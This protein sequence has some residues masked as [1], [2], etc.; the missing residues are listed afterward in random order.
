MPRCLIELRA[1]GESIGSLV[2]T[3]MAYVVWAAPK[4]VGQPFDQAA[5]RRF[6]P[7]DLAGR[8]RS[9]FIWDGPLA[10]GS[11]A[12]NARRP[13][14]A[15]E[16]SPGLASMNFQNMARDAAWF[17][18]NPLP[19][20]CGGGGIVTPPQPWSPCPDPTSVFDNNN[21]DAVFNAPAQPT[22]FR[23]DR[24]TIM[25]E[26]LTYHWNDGSGTPRPGTVSLR[27][28]SGTVYGP[29]TMVGRPGSGGAPN[30]YWVATPNAIVPAGAYTVE[31]SDPGTWARNR[32]SGEAGMTQIKGCPAGR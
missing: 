28:A 10:G 15:T 5:W 13:E 14:G 9:T 7:W 11:M 23:L 27:D 32:Q 16:I 30:A 4:V 25:T 24:P 22:T 2:K 21:I 31:D 29:W 1:G 8:Q 3:G 18:I 26:I 6:G 19:P 12:E 17:V 20:G